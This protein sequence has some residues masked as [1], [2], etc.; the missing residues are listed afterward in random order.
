MNPIFNIREMPLNVS[1]VC[2]KYLNDII[3]QTRKT[4][5]MPKFPNL[6]SQ[7]LYSAS[8]PKVQ[9]NVQQDSTINWKRSWKNLHFK[10]INIREREIVFKYLNNIIT[11]KK[12]LYQIKRA[13]SPLCELCD[14]IEDTKHM[15]CECIKVTLVKDYFKRLLR[16]ICN[17]DSRNM[18]KILHL[19]IVGHSNKDTNTAVVLT[20]SY[21]STIWFNRGNN[22]QIRPSL[23]QTSILKHKTLLSIIL[24]N[25]MTKLF[26][27]DNHFGFSPY[28][29]SM[30][31]KQPSRA[32][33]ILWSKS[34]GR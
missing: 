19:D 32:A 24:K 16:I 25:K 13:E 8:L 7:D 33:L 30:R 1:F 20:T 4:I 27:V 14:V 6:S 22:V 18:N 9:P 31:K 26:S 34:L 2:P 5:H 12:R 15:F 28:M 11:T 10:F 3:V 23:Y 21:I 29:K 17:I